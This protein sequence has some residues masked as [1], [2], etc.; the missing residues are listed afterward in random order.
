M[1]DMKTA[2][3]RVDLVILPSRYESF[4]YSALESLSL[5]KK[6]VLS[7]IPTH[8]EIALG[9]KFGFIIEK[10][11]PRELGNTILKAI[12][13]NPCSRNN[14]KWENKYSYDKWA[15]RYINFYKSCLTE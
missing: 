4:G 1:A 10:N 11:N 15:N 9:N 3:N 13:A 6:T 8:K 14:K 2:Y 5:Y 12:K 7:N